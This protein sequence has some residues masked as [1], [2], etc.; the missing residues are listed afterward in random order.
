MAES[1][2]EKLQ[3]VR[4]GPR[5]DWRYALDWPYDR[6][7]VPFVLG[8]LA[9]LC[10]DATDAKPF[11]D[12]RF[13]LVDRDNLDDVMQRMRCAVNLQVENVLA[14]DGSMLQVALTFR[15]L[16][17]FKPASIIQQVPA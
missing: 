9:D 2:H 1:Y 8:V 5:W 11:G 13:I 17:D 7:Y 10:G 14:D 6:R 16:S 3:R 12:R 15:R 4:K